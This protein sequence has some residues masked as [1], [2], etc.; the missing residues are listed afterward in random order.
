MQRGNQGAQS[1]IRALVKERGTLCSLTLTNEG[2]KIG[3]QHMHKPH[4]KTLHLKETISN[5][6]MTT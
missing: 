4:T 5:P 3:Q 1:Q 2:V 6:I